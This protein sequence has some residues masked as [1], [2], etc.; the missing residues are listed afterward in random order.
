[1]SSCQPITGLSFLS[2]VQF[3]FK[4]NRAPTLTYFVQ[5]VELPSISLQPTIR[6]TPFVNIPVPGDHI[7]Y[8]E[9]SVSFRVD[10]NMAN[11]LEIYQWLNEMGAPFSFSQ[12]NA[13]NQEPD[14][15]LLVLDSNS[16]PNIE[17]RFYEMFPTMLGSV[18]FN[19]TSTD[20]NYISSQAT[21]AYRSYE[22]KKLY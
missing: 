17:V 7:Q 5:T 13:E 15:V 14:G 20:I 19:V 16:R 6:P 22:I 4:L 1:M 12:Y 3:S 9:L 8:Q 18:D 21:F 11:W 10:E 2:P